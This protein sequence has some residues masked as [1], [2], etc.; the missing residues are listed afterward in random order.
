MALKNYEFIPIGMLEEEKFLKISSIP[1]T[2]TKKELV[3]V[4]K[5]NIDLF[6]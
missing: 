4:L 1:P 2:N 6:S 3:E 5:R